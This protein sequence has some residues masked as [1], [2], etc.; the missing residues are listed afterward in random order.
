MYTNLA[1]RNRQTGA[2]LGPE[3]AQFLILTK[4]SYIML[5]PG[6][7]ANRHFEVHSGCAACF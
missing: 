3:P 2:G 1:D 7:N 6:G 4:F 5:T